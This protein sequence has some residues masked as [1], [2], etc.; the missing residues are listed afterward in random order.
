MPLITLAEVKAFVNETSDDFNSSITNL[1]PAVTGRLREI[2]NNDFTAQPLINTV[3]QRFPPQGRVI[4]PYRDTA[5]YILPQVSATFDASSKTVTATGE[6]FAS[7]GF[8]GGQDVLVH[9]SYLNDGY[10][11]IDSIST[12]SL[13]VLSS[14]SF[15][16]AK[17]D[18]HQFIDEVTGAT[19]YFA[20]A[21]WPMDIKPVIASMI[22][23]D[24]QERGTWKDG[25]DGASPVGLYGYPK[26]VLKELLPWTELRFR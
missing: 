22:Q 18:T 26:S 17:A 19:I 24:Y 23:F 11:E 7:A 20:V 13:T 15:S 14:Y 3:Y 8:A 21:K 4:Q 9:G 6:N 1:I 10:Y 25:G 2:C 5:P 12:S 16:G